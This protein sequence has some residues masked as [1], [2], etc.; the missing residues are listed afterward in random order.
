VQIF[1]GDFRDEKP[2]RSNVLFCDCLHDEHEVTQNAPSLLAWLQPGSLLACHDVGGGGVGNT[3]LISSLRK[4]IP[5]GHG[6][7][8]DSTYV[9]EVAS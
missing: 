3:D 4:H 9:A 6:V 8:V 5:L 7:V 1:T 2:V